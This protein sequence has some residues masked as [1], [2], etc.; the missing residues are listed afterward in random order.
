MKDDYDGAEPAGSSLAVLALL[1]LAEL[2]GRPEWRTL[3][4]ET[5]TAAAARLREAPHAM[6]QMLV[7]A[8]HA[9]GPGVQVVIAGERG[10]PGVA[11]LAKVVHQRFLPA[12]A[13]IFADAETRARTSLP[14]IAAM[15]TIDGKAAA[16]VCRDHACDR[17]T[18]DPA[19]LA[20]KLPKIGLA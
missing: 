6:P 1:R 18:A 4:E 9:R 3:A 11:E 2:R 14:W 5:L 15:D 13:L 8:L 17:P 7:A 20:E 16:Y 12:R 10:D 19:E